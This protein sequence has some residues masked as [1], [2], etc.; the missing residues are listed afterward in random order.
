M[1]FEMI[2][3]PPLADEAGIGPDSD[4]EANAV[5]P[6]QRGHP[7]GALGAGSP[8]RRAGGSVLFNRD[9]DE[10]FMAGLAAEYGGALRRM[11]T[12]PDESWKRR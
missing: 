12:A 10:P 3:P 11:V 8:V 5:T 1:S 2:Q 4:T 7:N 6:V 9:D